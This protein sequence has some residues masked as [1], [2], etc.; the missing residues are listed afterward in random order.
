MG[1]DLFR[2]AGVVMVAFVASAPLARSPPAH[3]AIPELGGRE[4]AWN[5]NFWDFQLDPPPGAIT[6]R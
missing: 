6:G 5:V 2:I 3:H 1:Q 4:F